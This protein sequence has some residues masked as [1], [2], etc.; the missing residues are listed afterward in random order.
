MTILRDQLGLPSWAVLA[1]AGLMAHLA[2]NAALR[3]PLSSAWGMLAPLTLGVVVE[4]Y[5]IWVQYRGV[6]LL[7][8]GNDPIWLIV[9]RHGLDVATMLALPVLLVVAG[10][11]ASR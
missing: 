11:V 4:V 6:G 7:A 9:A 5:E 2:L 3:R 1:V 8:H 10:H